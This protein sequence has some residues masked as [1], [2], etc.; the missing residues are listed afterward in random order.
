MYSND[1]VQIDTQFM[2]LALEQAY[3]AQSKQEVPVGAV[4]VLDGKVV[5]KGFNQTRSGCDPSAHAEVGRRDAAAVLRNYRLNT[6]TLYVTLEPCVMCV[7][8]L[9]QARIARVVFG[10]ADQRFGAVCSA[11]QLRQS[12]A[13][14]H[15]FSV[16][17]GILSEDSKDYCKHFFNSAAKT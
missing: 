3:L 2:R 17:G 8:A 6:A 16:T 7:G 15:H 13:L 10:A 4:V 5:G 1:Q 11:V 12:G 9:G 14:N